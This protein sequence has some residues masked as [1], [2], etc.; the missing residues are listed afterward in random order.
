MNIK[1]II[2]KLYKIENDI[3]NLIIELE[4]MKNVQ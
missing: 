2:N 4:K 3:Q 1:K